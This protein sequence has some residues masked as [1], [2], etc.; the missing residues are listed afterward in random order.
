[1]P[2]SQ[3]RWEKVEK[4]ARQEKR[5]KNKT[6]EEKLRKTQVRWEKGEQTS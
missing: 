5:R 1:M 2:G 6:G 4:Q 3:V